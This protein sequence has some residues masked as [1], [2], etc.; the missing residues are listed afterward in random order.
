MKWPFGKK[1][2]KK[3]VSDSLVQYQS[4]IYFIGASTAGNQR[5]KNYVAGYKL[6]D[7]VYSCINLITQAALSVPWYVYRDTADGEMEE[8]D[9]HPFLDF[10]D[11]PG[12]GMDWNI[13]LTRAF[14][15][16]LTSGNAYIH[17]MIGSQGKY[18]EVE[19]LPSQYVTIKPDK[20]RKTIDYEYR[21]AGQ[22]FKFAE[23]EII[24][25]KAFNPEDPLYGLSPVQVLARKIDMAHLGELWTLSLLENEC[26]P[27]GALMLK[28]GLTS[29]QR[30]V[31]KKSLKDEYSGYENAGTP[32]IL[33]GDW[34][35]K[36]F[37]IT[38]K[39]LN[40]LQSSKKIMREICAA[41]KVAPELFGD[42]E[43]KT[44]SNIKEARKALYQEAALPLL[45]VF[46]A[47]F[48]RELFP[49][50]DAS[51]KYF[52]D[53]D[54]SG[55]EA[56]SEDLD[57][58]WGRVG[59]AKQKNRVITLNEAREAL[60]YETIEGGDEVDQPPAPPTFSGEPGKEP[61]KPKPDEKLPVE[62]PEPKK[63]I[64]LPVIAQKTAPAHPGAI[65]GGFWQKA[66]R[67]EAKWNAFA[68]RVQSREAGIKKIAAQ[69]LHEQAERIAK[70]VKKAPS[71]NMLDRWLIL[72]KEKEAGFFVDSAIRWY[73]D[74]FTKAVR[75]GMAAGKGEI[76]D[77]EEKVWVFKPEF[78][79]KL[80]KMVVESGT[81]IA[82]T[83]MEDV[84]DLLEQAETESWTVSE[85]AKH[86]QA[87]MG[88]IEGWRARR[89]AMTE[90]AKV[91]NYGE[92]TGYRET[93]FIELKGWLC[94]FLEHSRE[95]HIKA[96]ADYSDDPIPLDDDFIIGPD[97]EHL[98]YPGDPR[99]TAGEIINCHCT[100]YPQVKEL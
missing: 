23:D 94:S 27:S 13:F 6:N 7:T 47:A 86:V 71:L 61:V 59:D 81:K 84:L 45:G 65:K 89:I 2:E 88:E 73:I 3:A 37:S 21:V 10:M 67:K 93:E 19:V 15:F 66:E 34:D 96:D 44:Y 39:E 26:R 16:Y 48:N 30:E 69:H 70:Q 43:N 9:N 92:L 42:S 100:L 76:S 62:E 29:D 82:E 22:M 40:F 8:V 17:K 31:L 85:L 12:P 35:W 75:S 51:G 55:V 36:S 90:A 80:R 52:L 11:K 1:I 53:Y 57:L 50:F 4:G 14:G 49:K 58:L 79:A 38:P 64:I 99:G 77:G 18:G 68:R 60:N 91:E 25:V 56:L 83:T 87:K 74:S 54:T 46:K 28:Q 72:D 63:A 95:T 41:Y 33:E 98:A 20:L 97:H 24:H 5:L 78:E 32:L